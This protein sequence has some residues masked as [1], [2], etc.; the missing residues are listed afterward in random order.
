M[1]NKEIVDE[2]Q[3]ERA[4]HEIEIDRLLT[5]AS[6]NGMYVPGANPFKYPGACRDPFRAQAPGPP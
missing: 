1:T 2:L 6:N 3:A 5:E 4:R